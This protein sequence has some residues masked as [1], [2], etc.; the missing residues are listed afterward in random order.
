MSATL[1]LT[2]APMEGSGKA[3]PNCKAAMKALTLAGHYGRYV[4]VHACEPC[5]L[6]WF[7]EF[8]SVNLAALG[9]LTLVREI[10]RSHER[11]HTPSAS[12][13]NCASCDAPLKLTRDKTRYGQTLQHRCPSGHGA[14]QTFAQ[15]LA[16]KGV[17][18]GL[19]RHEAQALMKAEAQSSGKSAV[20]ARALFCMNCGALHLPQRSTDS[21]CAYCGSA[22]L[23]LDMAGLLAVIDPFDATSDNAAARALKLLPAQHKQLNCPHCGYALDATLHAHCP[24]CRETMTVTDMRYALRLLEALTPLMQRHHAQMPGKEMEARLA[25]IDKDPTNRARF[26]EQLPPESKPTLHWQDYSMETVA[27]IGLFILL[28]AVCIILYLVKF[29]I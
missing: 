8:K 23:A 7:D 9:I 22:F 27:K 14:A 5:H 2:L 17:V 10:V 13:L 21:G 15:Y 18:R 28:V 1:E 24:S 11:T 6:L 4:E 3:C 12:A 29:G 20:P 16:E 25:I 19:T 26:S